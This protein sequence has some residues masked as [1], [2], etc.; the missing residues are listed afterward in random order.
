MRHSGQQQIRGPYAVE[1]F[2]GK[3]CLKRQIRHVCCT[4]CHFGNV[5]IVT[6]NPGDDGL[7]CS[8]ILQG[9]CSPG[10]C[11]THGEPAEGQNQ[12]AYLQTV[13]G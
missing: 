4:E 5:R 10:S 1:Q 11:D 7:L 2:G 12:G 3:P 13:H 8:G 6:L 9:E